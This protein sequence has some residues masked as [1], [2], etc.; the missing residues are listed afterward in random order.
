MQRKELKGYRVI[1]FNENWEADVK[2][3][4]LK[5]G[6]TRLA[7]IGNQSIDGTSKGEWA[8]QGSEIL[9]V[10][11]EI[12]FN[13]I[14]QVNEPLS[15]LNQNKWRSEKHYELVMCETLF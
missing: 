14:H 7:R 2:E 12:F 13:H 3:M 5:G 11:K 15:I 9:K 6:I 8:Q 10:M 4:F 1:N